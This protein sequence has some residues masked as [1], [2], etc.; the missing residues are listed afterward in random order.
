MARIFKIL[1]CFCAQEA[2]QDKFKFGPLPPM[3]LPIRTAGGGQEVVE[4]ENARN[5]VV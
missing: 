1:F 2:F 4:V 3:R 5:G